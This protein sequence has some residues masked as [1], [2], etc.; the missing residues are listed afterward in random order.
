MATGKVK[1]VPRVAVAEPALVMVGAWLTV[2]VTFWVT[3]PA[4]LVAVTMSGNTPVAVGV[5]AKV[6]VPLVPATKLTPA[7]RAPVSVSVGAG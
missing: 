4:V 5:P 3:V 6:A 7:G 1:A 2:S